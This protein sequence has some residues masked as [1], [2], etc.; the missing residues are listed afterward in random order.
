M[1]SL[2][3]LK[4]FINNINFQFAAPK[5]K[6]AP[7]SAPISHEGSS[8]VSNSNSKKVQRFHAAGVSAVQS[9]K[10]LPR[11]DG[12]D[13]HSHRRFVRD[14]PA[15]TIPHHRN[16]TKRARAHGSSVHTG[17]SAYGGVGG[18]SSNGVIYA[19]PNACAG[20]PSSGG[21]Q[22]QL[23]FLLTIVQS[24][25]LVSTIYLNIKIITKYLPYSILE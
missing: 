5:A 24:L 17:G 1:N 16:G 3:Y 20:C 8:L 11:P 10:P 23:G 12:F 4:E 21:S 2:I 25:D 22:N 7:L 14:V 18:G 9:A 15:T 13:A 6:P 19:D